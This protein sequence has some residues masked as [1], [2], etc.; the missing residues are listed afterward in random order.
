MLVS[1]RH[2]HG[3]DAGLEV[4]VISNEIFYNTYLFASTETH[5]FNV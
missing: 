3:G 1:T 2:N 5:E 4:R